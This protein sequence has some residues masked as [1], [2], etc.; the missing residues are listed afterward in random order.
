M[1]DKNPRHHS[2]FA[3]DQCIEISLSESQSSV[4]TLSSVAVYS[5][6]L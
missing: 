5:G 2:L 1:V 3:A 4:L 6:S